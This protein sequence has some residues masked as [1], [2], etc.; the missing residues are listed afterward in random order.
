MLG[1]LVMFGYDNYTQHKNTVI[2]QQ[3]ENLLTIAKSISRSLDS[4]IDNKSDCL[5]ILSQ[6]PIIIESLINNRNDGGYGQ[7]EEVIKNYYSKSNDEIESILLLD[8]KGKLIYEYPKNSYTKKTVNESLINRVLKNKRAIVTKEYESG[9]N[10][11]SIDILQPVF[12]NNEI[13]GILVSTINLNNLYKNLIASIR[14]GKKGYAMIKNR[15]GII[16]MHPV[17][18][19]IG[20]ESIRVRKAMYPN[21]DWRE[22]EELNRR[23][24]EEGEGY[25]IYHSKWWQDN[26]L[27]LFKKINAFTTIKADDIS[28]IISVQTDYAEVE[29]PIN[30]T[31]I[32]ISMIALVITIII[33]IAGYIIFKIEKRRKALEI[34]T[35]YLKELNKTWEEL[36]ES[37]ARLRH[38]QKL[39]TIGILTS[40]IAHEFNNL[41]TPILGYSEILLQGVDSKDSMYEDICEIKKSALRAKEII[42]Q[43]LVFSR[44]ENVTSKVMPLRVDNIVRESIKMVKAILPKNIRVVENINCSRKILGNATQLQQVLVNLYTNSFHAMKVKGG[45]LRL[46]VETVDISE[47]EC[48]ELNLSKGSY[49]KIQVEDT[50]VGMNEETLNKIFDPFFTTKKTGEGT[51]LGLSVVH[52]IVRDHNGSINVRSQINVGTIVDIYLPVAEEKIEES[53]EKE[54]LKLQGEGDILFVDD[55]ISVLRMVKKALNSCGYNVTTENDSYRAMMIFDKNPFAFKVIVIDYTMPDIN[56]IEAARHFK[57]KNPDVKIILISGYIKE[58]IALNYP[59]LFED[60]MLKPI[61]VAELVNKIKNAQN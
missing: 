30:G 8:K 12:N 20:I 21:F 11:F 50:G 15:E 35:K 51:G 59:D 43:I 29:Q 49:V 41:L 16:V 27:K 48:I 53:I 17:K 61:I 23:Q 42:E 19:Q 22:L 9:S 24:V 45:L 25:Y 34:E 57:M 60:F 47:T 1:V 36:I 37:E 4:Y 28:W 7:H 5:Y 6:N 2:R 10:K 33:L 46:N 54:E 31:L 40:G 39:Q 3:Q 18:E 14:P 44:N 38:S 58:D 56:G 32:N 26:E 55:N 13:R 52:G